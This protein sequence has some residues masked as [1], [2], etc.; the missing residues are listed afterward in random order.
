MALVV[1]ILYKVSTINSSK[2][3]YGKHIS[4]ENDVSFVFRLELPDI[5]ITCLISGG[6]VGRF[7]ELMYRD[8]D[9]KTS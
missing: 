6:K 4:L 2:G 7:L 3:I 1:K 5:I 9:I 8:E